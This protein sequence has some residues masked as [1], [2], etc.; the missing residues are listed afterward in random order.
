MNPFR[1]F[2][3]HAG[4]SYDPKTETPEQGRR[5]CA[6]SLADAEM[7]ARD[8][9]CS[10]QWEVDPHARSSDWIADHEDGGKYRD[11][12]ITWQCCMHDA[13][14]EAIASLGGIDFGRN[15]SP[16]GSPYKRVVE[17]EL[18]LESLT[19]KEQGA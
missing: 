4:Y 3:Q 8:A 2:M 1:F 6:R 9:G 16:F 11:P 12:W 7:R 5:R 10:Y 17:A 13:E 19:E 14:G 15:G 18:A